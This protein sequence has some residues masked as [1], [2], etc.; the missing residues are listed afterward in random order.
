MRPVTKKRKTSEEKRKERKIAFLR[1]V[2]Q[3]IA[4]KRDMADLTQGEVATR[5]DIGEEAVSR[6]E[7]GTAAPDVFRL[8][9]LA[10][11]FKCGIDELVV[12]SSQRRK[13]QSGRILSMLRHLNSADRELV[14]EVVERLCVRLGQASPSPRDNTGTA[15]IER[16]TSITTGSEFLLPH[17]AE[18]SPRPKKKR[19]QSKIGNDNF[20]L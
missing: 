20:L 5:L 2:G 6:M 4:K 1:R 19:A 7:R 18:L 10:T 13:D 16:R 9:E 15:D 14:V 12:E 11:L 3:T 17:K 8:H